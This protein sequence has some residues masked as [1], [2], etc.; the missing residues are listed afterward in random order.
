MRSR[1]ARDPV[2]LDPGQFGY[3]GVR[4]W[5]DTKRKKPF[6]A[7]VK[8]DGEEFRSPAFSMPHEAAVAYDVLA[9]IL[10]GEKAILNF[11]EPQT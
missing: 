8:F 5:K 6:Y 1:Y 3:R 7:R 11:P 10:H 9:K 4:K 2:P